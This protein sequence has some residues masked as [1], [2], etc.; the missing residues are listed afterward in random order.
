MRVAKNIFEPRASRIL[1]VL[2]SNPGRAW[3]IR[4]LADEAQVSHGYTHAVTAALAQNGYVVRN[5]TYRIEVVD[6]IR[7]L[8]RW[9]SYHQY[10]SANTFLDYYAFEREIDRLIERLRDVRREYALTGLIGAWLV[11]PHVRPVMVEA[12]VR[13]EGAARG[14]AEDLGLKPTPKEGNVRLVVPY[15]V[16]VFYRTQA[17][18]GV[19]VVSNVQ[20]YVDLYNYP[21][22]GEEA[23][24]YVLGLIEKAWGQALLRGVSHV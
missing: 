21:A 16:G 8:K 3:T 2:L 10:D 24:T 6:P 17:T 15:D 14:L 13:G 5:E 7:M 9:S 20:L 22:R 12:Y 11:A 23:A 1:R 4:E 18:A 19:Q